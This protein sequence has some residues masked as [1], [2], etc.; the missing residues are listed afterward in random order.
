MR[1]IAFML[2]L[3]MCL[4]SMFVA[5]NDNPADTTAPDLNTTEAVAP[6]TTTE[7]TPDTTEKAPDTTVNDTTDTT[8]A[9]TE[10]T[11]PIPTPDPEPEFTSLK[12]T[13]NQTSLCTSTYD[14][15]G[16]GGFNS[17]TAWVSTDYIEINGWYGFEY[18]MAAHKKLMSVAFYTADKQ[19]ISGIGTTSMLGTV[20]TV[21][22]FTTI[23]ENAKYVRFINYTSAGGDMPA[24]TDHFVNVFM[25][26]ENYDMVYGESEY[27]E[28]VIACLGD[29]LTEGDYGSNTAGVANRKYKNYPYYLSKALGCKTINYGKC[30]A[31]SQSFYDSYY[32][33]D[34][35]D[36]SEADVIVI[37]LG[38]NRGLEGDY[39]SYYTKLIDDVKKDMKKGA[40]VIL[41]TPPSATIDK[42][43]VNGKYMPNLI[44]SYTVVKTMATLKKTELIDAFKYSPIQPAMEEV[45]QAND[46]LHMVEA[47]Y[48]AFGEYMAEEIVKILNK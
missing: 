14:G 10:T 45:Y 19:Y 34:Q 30:G 23:P 22:G 3:V 26:K 5:C 29:S 40:K 31:N 16:E 15:K 21:S 17:Y 11:E 37:M 27:R 47:G 4:G 36:I 13:F 32:N 20:T 7:K 24:Y 12:M 1:K 25:D 42:T 48:K 33:K 44:A 2:A 38:T 41:V 46:G 18:E 28:L 8:S 35:V 6:D 39:Q 9:P 43:K